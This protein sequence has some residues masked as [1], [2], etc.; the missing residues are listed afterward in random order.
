V[1]LAVR[2]LLRDGPRLASMAARAKHAGR[3]QAA[4]DIAAFVGQAGRS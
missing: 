3:P 4:H 1:P 2:Q